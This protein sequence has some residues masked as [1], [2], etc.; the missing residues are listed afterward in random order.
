MRGCSALDRAE[1]YIRTN[2]RK[3]RGLLIYMLYISEI[4]L[5]ICLT[6][7]ISFVGNMLK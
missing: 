3:L 1:I 6:D 5:A 4:I 2:W 7:S